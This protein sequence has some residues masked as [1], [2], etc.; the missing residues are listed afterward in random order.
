[1]WSMNRDGKDPG[2]PRDLLETL[3]EANEV[4]AVPESEWGALE[5]LFGGDLLAKLLQISP[6]SVRRYRSSARATPDDVAARLHFLAKVAGD[7]AGTY[8]EIGVRRWFQRPRTALDG[9]APVDLLTA[10]WDPDAPDPTRV[11]KLSRS[12]LSSPA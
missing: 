2:V 6:A 9:K 11:R 8:D 12:L 1:M 4:A 7:L 10:G 5:D 3:R